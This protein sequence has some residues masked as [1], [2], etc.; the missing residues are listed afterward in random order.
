MCGECLSHFVSQPNST[1]YQVDI[2]SG[3]N[4]PQVLMGV[5][6][7][8]SAHTR[9]YTRPPI[10]TSGNFPAHLSAES[11][12]NLPQPLRSHI[13]SF[14]TLR[15]LLKFSKY[16]LKMPPRGP[17]GV[18]KNCW[19]VNISFFEFYFLPKVFIFIS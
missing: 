10:N 14:G 2:D 16:K 1:S 11:H 18:S 5:L 9:P 19:G 8:V 4:F 17:G 15:Q 7:H 3:S 6:A 13:R 12:S